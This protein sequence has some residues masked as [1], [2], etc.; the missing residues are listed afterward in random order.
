MPPHRPG[1]R[2][3]LS[4]HWRT[5]PV[6]P[7]CARVCR[8]QSLRPR[9]TG[10]RAGGLAGWW[11]YEFG[12]YAILVRRDLT[13]H[14][15]SYPQLSPYLRRGEAAEMQRRP[16]AWRLD[17]ER[18]ALAVELFETTAEG[19]A[20][21]VA[22]LLAQAGA[23]ASVHTVQR[24]LAPWRREKEAAQVDRTRPDPSAA[25][26]ASRPLLAGLEGMRR[27]RCRRTLSHRLVGWCGDQLSGLQAK[28]GPA[29]PRSSA[30][31]SSTSRSSSACTRSDSPECTARCVGWSSACCGGSC[32]VAWSNT[33]SR[34]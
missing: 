27:S 6:S 13:M 21:V 34:G 5:V 8:R 22:E 9:G 18:R 3:P 4:S 30:W 17:V 19:N 31:S 10:T 28:T 23:K 14:F 7:G 11:P 16:G 20:V 1:R 25:E 32:A 12:G 29:S 33:A 2:P 15:F 26:T 24:V